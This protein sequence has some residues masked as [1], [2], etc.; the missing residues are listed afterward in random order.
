MKILAIDHG[1]SCGYAVIDDGK[2]DKFGTVQLNITDLR[3]MF[4][5]FMKIMDDVKPEFVVLEKVNVHGTKFGAMNVLKLQGIQTIVRLTCELLEIDY[6]FINPKT[7]KKY[8]TGNGNATKTDVAMA[9]VDRWGIEYETLCEHIPYKKKE[10]TKEVLY[11]ASD[12]LALATC[13]YCQS[14]GIEPKEIVNTIIEGV[15]PA[16]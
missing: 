8:L 4:F 7:L 10:G 16:L 1:T 6:D 2:V 11:D 12:A 9:M 15:I 3:E 13:Y 14:E 5:Q